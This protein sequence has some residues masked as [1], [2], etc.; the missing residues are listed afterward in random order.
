MDIIKVPLYRIEFRLGQQLCGTT[1]RYYHIIRY[2]TDQRIRSKLVRIYPTL[3]YSNYDN[4]LS[5]NQSIRQ[6]YHIN[7]LYQNS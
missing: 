7:M 3:D 1:L 6:L 2:R 4:F 5:V